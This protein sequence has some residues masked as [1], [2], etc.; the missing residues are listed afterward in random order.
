MTYFNPRIY[1]YHNLNDEDRYVVNGM[2]Y[3]VESLECAQADYDLYD[4][5]TT[6]DKIH[7]EIVIE[8]LQEAQERLKND[9]VE[10]MVTQIDNYKDDVAEIDTNDYFIGSRL[11]GD[12]DE[13]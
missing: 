3:L 5:E 1:N 13:D 10:F 12:D 7:S 4:N 8:T 9:I 6:L 2:I 11:E